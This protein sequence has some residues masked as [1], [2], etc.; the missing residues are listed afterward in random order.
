MPA[1]T[2][3]ARGDLGIYVHWPF[4][5]RKC[6]YCDFNVHIRAGV[7]ERPWRVALAAELAHFARLVPGRTVGSV[8]FGGGT[9]SLMAPDSVAAVLDAAARH[10]ALAP[11]V[12][13]SL[14]ANPEDAERLA[15]FRAA[16]VTRLS[17]GVQ[18]LR[19]PDLVALGR[20]HSAA[21]AREVVALAQHLFAVTS[22]DLIYARPG[23]RLEA[24]RDE[25]GEA[26]ALAGG[27][28][29][30]YQL[31]FEP[32]TVFHH[33]LR[34]GTLAAPAEDTTAALYELTQEIC[35]AAGYAA[36][37]VSNHAAPGHR[38]RHNLNYWRGGDYIG[39]GPGAHGRL[40]L[41]E[42]R[43][44]TRQRRHPE[45]WL[46]AVGSAGHASE[47]QEV[48]DRDAVAAEFLMMGLRLTEGVSLPAFAEAVGRPL[49][50]HLASGRL[51][52]L[53]HGGLL[54]LDRTHLRATPRGR[55]VLD[56]VLG[57]LLP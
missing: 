40:T 12:E 8:Y 19:D 6:P 14:E 15:D 31:T 57:E 16:G 22:F 2:P 33:A 13:V 45:T 23:Q 36:Y 34:R 4:C 53:V 48:L 29:S 44:A 46:A 7:D 5:V 20:G 11:D 41:G 38:S 56:A 55:P 42:G 1:S 43:V 35:N 18:S 52:R 51:E 9:P 24:W 10:F 30:L 37:E 47:A 54:V 25:L 26:L 50:E 21:Q 39:I 17:L 3:E 27:H 49:A 28:L 32:G